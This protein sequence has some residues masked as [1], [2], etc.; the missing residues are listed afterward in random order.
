MDQDIKKLL[1]RNFELTRENNKL[2][3]KIRRNAIVANVM[4]LVWWSVIIGVPLFL[5]HYV[6]QP[7]LVDLGAAYQ[8]VTDGVSGAQESFLK[9]P[10]IRDFITGFTGVEAS[11]PTE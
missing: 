11:T 7:Y 8:G 6:L 5:Y 2:L 1:R 3:K 4:R 10:F 9:I